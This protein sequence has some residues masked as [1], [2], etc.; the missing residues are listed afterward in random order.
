MAVCDTHESFRNK[1]LLGL[2][3]LLVGARTLRTGLLASLRTEQGL[4]LCAL[5]DNPSEVPRIDSCTGAGLLHEGTEYIGF[6]GIYRKP[7]EGTGKIW[8]C[9]CRGI[10]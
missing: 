10:Y 2:L 5:Y 4:L 8:V 6:Q 9:L 1:K 7:D 3:A